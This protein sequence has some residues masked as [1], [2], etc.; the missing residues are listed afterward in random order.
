MQVTEELIKEI[1]ACS[2]RLSESSGKISH[3]DPI[4]DHIGS[5]TV[6]LLGMQRKRW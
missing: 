5:E 1:M 2:L 6:F 4:F 3:A